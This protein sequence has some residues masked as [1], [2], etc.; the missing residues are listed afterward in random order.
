M[1]S[2]ESGIISVGEVVD[3]QDIEYSVIIFDSLVGF[4]KISNI[5]LVKMLFGVTKLSHKSTVH[6]YLFVKQI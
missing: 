6:I 3:A 5:C 1:C 4:T 2:K